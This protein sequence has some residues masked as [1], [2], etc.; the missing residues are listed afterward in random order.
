MISKILDDTP[1]P[2]TGYAHRFDKD[3]FC[4]NC[5]D[6][7]A[8]TRN[9]NFQDRVQVWVEAAFGSS[10]KAERI[11]RFIEEALELAQAL[12]CSEEEAH[13]LVNYV[14]SRGAG[15]PVQELGGTMTTLAALSAVHGFNMQAAGE[16]ELSRMWEDIEK[17]RIKQRNKPSCSPLPQ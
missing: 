8:D 14:F 11:H 1:C 2:A 4:N 16:L 15:E 6:P 12:G 13:L 9:D 3:G 7:V 10:S 5:N 17:I